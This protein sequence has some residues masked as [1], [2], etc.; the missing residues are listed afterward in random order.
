MYK[1]YLSSILYNYLVYNKDE[2]QSKF[3]FFPYYLFGYES[4]K[5]FI[6]DNKDNIISIILLLDDKVRD[7]ILSYIVSLLEITENILL[8][9]CISGIAGYIDPIIYSNNIEYLDKGKNI[10]TY[11]QVYKN[12]NRV[13]YLIIHR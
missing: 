10:I 12:Y 13:L 5:S 8:N 6:E 11:I 2:N 4:I 7:D 1:Y 9:S 3:Q